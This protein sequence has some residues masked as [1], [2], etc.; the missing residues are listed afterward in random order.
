M[1]DT[2]QRYREFVERKAHSANSDPVP[3]KHWPNMTKDFQLSLC[4]TSLTRGRSG[5]FAD[6]GLGKTLMELIFAENVARFTGGNV[7]ILAPLAVTI[8]MIPEAE[9]FGFDANRSVDGTVHRI[10]VTNYEKLGMFNPADF[11]AVV[12]DESSILKSFDGATKTAI[13]DFMKRVRYR[14]L[15][16]ATA[17]P[18]DFTELGTSSEALGY[19]GYMDMLSKFFK[20]DNNTSTDRRFYGEAPEWRLKGHAERAFWQWVASWS[21]ACRKPSDIGFSDEG[22]I[23]PPLEVIEHLVDVEGCPD[24]ALFA[25]PANNLHDQRREK[26]RTVFERCERA[27][28]LV[29]SGGSA[30]VWCQLNDEAEALMRMIPGAVEVNGSDKDDV[31]ERKFCQFLSGESRVLVTKPKIGAWGL[32]FQ[33]ASNMV[34]FP[35]HSYEQYYQSVRRMYRFGQRETVR[36]NL[37]MTEGEK[38]IMD[39]LKKKSAKAETMFSNLVAEMSAANAQSKSLAVQAVAEVPSWV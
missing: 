28:S 10:T 2:I 39:N 17:A 9:K 25:M 20:N 15:A 4:E 16:T 22:Y 35:S 33:H 18:N 24:D 7:L 1:T 6:C 21:T 19:M 27:A 30:I 23:L 37:V 8:Q 38:L 34:Y 3:L 36:V 31:K 13:T 32:N 14:L 29:E 12:C 11:A 5:I 26:K